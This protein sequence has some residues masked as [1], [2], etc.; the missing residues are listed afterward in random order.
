M[1]SIKLSNG[2]PVPVGV[3]KRAPV[4]YSPNA[5]T[6][7]TV[8]IFVEVKNT[9]KEKTDV[10]KLVPKVHVEVSKPTIEYVVGSKGY[11]LRGLESTNVVNH[12]HD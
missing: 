11:V 9:E 2:A 3:E 12:G 7:I 10:V 4:D 5:F 8:I 1:D 6:V